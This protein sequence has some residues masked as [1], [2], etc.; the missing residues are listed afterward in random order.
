MVKANPCRLRHPPVDR[1][2]QYAR[3]KPCSNARLFCCIYS[4]EKTNKIKQLA[5]GALEWLSI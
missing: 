2:R 4:T 5:G 1:A 3:L